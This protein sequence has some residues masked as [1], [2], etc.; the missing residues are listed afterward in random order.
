MLTMGGAA[1]EAASCPW[2]NAPGAKKGDGETG[3]T[4]VYDLEDACEQM[5][6]R[7]V[8]GLTTREDADPKGSTRRE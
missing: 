5:G 2:Q 4:E 6:R 8:Q 1:H 3:S 7:E